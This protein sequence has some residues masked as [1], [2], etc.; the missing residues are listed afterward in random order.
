MLKKI[1]AVVISTIIFSL[2]AALFAGCKSTNVDKKQSLV[3]IQLNEVARSIFYAPMYAAINEGFFKEQGLDIDLVTGQG[4]DKTMQQVLS[5]NSDIGFC[6]SEQVLYL[7][8]Q[9]REDYAVIFAQLTKRDG[10]FFVSRDPDPNFTWDHVKGKNILGGRP[11]GVPEM[12][13]EYVLKSNGISMSFNGEKPAKDVNIIT[14]VAY[15][16]TASAFK[17]GTGDYVALFEPSGTILEQ[18][19]KGY[20][21]SSIG[22]ES[23]ELPYTC[24]FATKS[25]IEKHPDI[26]Q[27]FTNALYK[28]I[29]WVDSHSNDEVAKSIKSF[30]AGTDEKQ[31]SIVVKRYRDQDSWQKDLIVKKEVLERFENLIYEYDSRLMPKKPPY[32]KVVT[33]KFAKEAAKN[34]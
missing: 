14:N 8:N 22:K 13:L 19:G 24:F 6:G 7:Y 21:V 9:G 18:E 26:I 1:K 23:G 28:G 20:I 29:V 5:K 30:F 33:D 2:I 16:A 11:G 17:G 31:I 15:A 12:S 10:S 34:K 32:E 3:K 27:K 25:Y 4:A